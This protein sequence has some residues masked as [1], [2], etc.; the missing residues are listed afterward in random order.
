MTGT[1]TRP[2]KS[3]ASPAPLG[4]ALPAP[5]TF[6]LLAPPP[7]PPRCPPPGLLFGLFAGL[8]GLFVAGL[9]QGRRPVW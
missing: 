4:L 9:P 5:P 7:Y 1:A 8:L 3:T 6:L 2:A